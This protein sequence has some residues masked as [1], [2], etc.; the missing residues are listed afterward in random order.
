[1]RLFPTTT[2]TS[3][4]WMS[5]ALTALLMTACNDPVS[6]DDASTNSN[7]NSGVIDDP[8][9]SA[10]FKPQQPQIKH[11]LNAGLAMEISEYGT[12]SFSCDHSPFPK[13]SLDELASDR[14]P[15]YAIKQIAEDEWSLYNIKQPELNGSFALPEEDLVFYK[16]FDDKYFISFELRSDDCASFNFESKLSPIGTFPEDHLE[17]REITDPLQTHD[18]FEVQSNGSWTSGCF[19]HPKDVWSQIDSLSE[20]FF[21][22]YEMQK[23]GQTWYALDSDDPSIK[24]AID[25]QSPSYEYIAGADSGEYFIRLNYDQD[26]DCT[27]EQ[28]LALTVK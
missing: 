24:L 11:P 3:S 27:Y 7:D 8:S 4:S 13:D 16:Y 9:T 17:A 25:L 22:D 26:E 20:S 21:V 18:H 15:D 28:D 6:S 14:W 2:K 5:L 12:F 10:I 19:D 23:E 1:M